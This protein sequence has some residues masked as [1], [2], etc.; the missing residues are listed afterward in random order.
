MLDIF[1]GNIHNTLKAWQA[2]NLKVLLV[3]EMARAR[4]STAWILKG[5]SQKSIT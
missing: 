5:G 2:C 3:G 1:C 4:D